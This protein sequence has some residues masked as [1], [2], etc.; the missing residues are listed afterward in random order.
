MRGFLGGWGVR[1]LIIA[2]IAVGA[3]VLKDRISG[4]AGDLK[5]GDCFD[6]PVGTTTVETVQH[7]PCSESHTSEVVFVGNVPG[8]KATYPAQSVFDQ[9]GVGNCIPAFNAY[10]GKDFDTETVL[11]M[12][13]FY[14]LADGWAKGDQEMTCYAIRVDGGAVTSSVKKA[15]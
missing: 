9:Y 4:N 14:P 7:H 12:S 6:E 15:P 13:Y 10:T 2:V 11:T 3:F 8:D 1:I 5:V